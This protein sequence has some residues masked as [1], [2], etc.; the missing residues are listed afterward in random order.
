MLKSIIFLKLVHKVRNGS[1]IQEAVQDIVARGVGEL[2]KVA[3]AED[4]EDAKNMPWSRE[5]AW[6]IIKQLAKTEEVGLPKKKNTATRY[7]T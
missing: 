5:Q 6:G 2:R 1:T 3:F 7:L 4:A